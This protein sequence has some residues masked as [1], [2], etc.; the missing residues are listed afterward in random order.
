VLQG[1]REDGAVMNRYDYDAFGN[2]VAANTSETVENRY[3]FQGREWDAHRGDYYFRNRTYVP[4]WGCFT[5]PDGL[6]G[7]SPNGDPASPRLAP[8][9]LPKKVRGTCPRP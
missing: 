8:G 3:G 6:W 2:A 9:R 1:I 4:E 5:G 7:H